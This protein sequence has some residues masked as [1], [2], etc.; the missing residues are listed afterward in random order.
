MPV[1]R[2]RGLTPNLAE[3]ANFLIPGLRRQMMAAAAGMTDVIALGRGDPDIDTPAH[4]IEA[5]KRA[6]DDGYTHYTPWNGYPQLRA[7]IARKLKNEN[8]VEV[9]PGSQ[10]LVTGGAQEAVFI[11]AQVLLDPGDEVLIPDPHYGS[12]DVSIQLAGGLVVPV[13]TFEA[14]DFEVE[15]DALESHV[16]PRSKVLVIVNPN[17]PSGNVLARD[18]LLAIAEFVL[19]HDLIVISDDI[20]EKYIYDGTPH[21]SFASLPGMA[22]RTIT[23]NSLSKTYAMTGWRIGYLAGPQDFITRAGELKYALSICPPAATQIAA[24]AAL[25]GPQDHIA[26]VVQTYRDRRG[27]LLKELDQIG[28]TYGMPQGGFTVLANISATGMGSVEFCL[29]VLREERVQVFPGLMYGPSGEGY[30]RIS[31]LVP[32]ETL[33]EA[34]GRIGQVVAALRRH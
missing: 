27:V 19:R 23:I 20:Y 13:P 30:A 32:V 25:D 22:D 1:A 8:G 18:K 5:A 29:K 28:L 15:L 7:A 4:I 6:L 16:T 9:D 11:A 21:V 17:N 31:F 34:M 24:V 33:R 26:K 10:I 12:Y 14:R 2:P 3:R